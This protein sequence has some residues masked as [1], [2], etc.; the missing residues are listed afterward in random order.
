MKWVRDI[1][2]W[3][4]VQ[5]RE[6]K[7]YYDQFVEDHPSLFAVVVVT[8]L[9]TS[10]EITTGFMDMLRLGDG[11]AE[12]TAGGF[13]KD[14]LR[15]LG[16]LGP[17]GKLFRLGQAV[18]GVELAR[19]IA[20][21]G[22][23]ICAWVAMTKALRQ[24]GQ[25]TFVSVPDLARAA[26]IN[27]ADYMG[28]TPVPTIVHA[29]RQLGARFGRLTAVRSMGDVQSLVPRD[30]SVVLFSAY[31]ARAGHMM[32]AFRDTLGRLRI[33]D[34]TGVYSALSEMERF[35]P[36]IA[37]ANPGEAI[38][39]L[40]VFG[41]IVGVE[42][43]G[44]LAMELLAYTHGEPEAVAQAFEIR[45]RNPGPPTGTVAVPKASTPSGTRR[46]M[47]SA[48]ESLSKISQR[49]YGSL[50]KWPVIYEANRHAIGRNPNRIVVGVDL[51]IPELPK[52][53]RLPRF[54]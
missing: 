50:F 20:D 43:A 13:G 19:G 33:M 6:A 42:Q 11:V 3:W 36:G 53:G 14:A 41:K 15:L 28:G 46:H 2:D 51:F 25:K 18:R 17:A 34:R 12:G 16:I 48:G 44:M 26:G 49:Y 47:I 29:L 5:H 9:E 35:Y 4:D 10:M 52:V 7:A 24:T 45:K 37:S 39:V 22:G 30:G 21:P 1:A 32:Y 38:R 23:G 27:L 40:N 54:Q 31:W 8:T